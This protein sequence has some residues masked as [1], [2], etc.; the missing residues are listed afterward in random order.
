MMNI[1]LFSAAIMIEAILLVNYL[2]LRLIEVRLP[3]PCSSLVKQLTI[4]YG[5]INN[6]SFKR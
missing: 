2:R 5:N 6:K 1:L 3:E 4:F